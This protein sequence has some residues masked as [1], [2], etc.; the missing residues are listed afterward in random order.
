MIRKFIK[1]EMFRYLFIGGCTTLLDIALFIG[2]CQFTPLG[3]DKIGITVANTIAIILS[4]IFAYY[5]NK[6]FVFRKPYIDVKHE[7]KEMS[8]F[9]I[10][11]FFT[12]LIEIGG[13][14]FALNVLGQPKLVGK[15]EI[16]FVVVVMNY[17]LS[18]F[19][20]FKKDEGV[21]QSN[22]VRDQVGL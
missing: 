18:K 20:V 1:S 3:N 15:I 11:R 14:Y 9:F 12:M 6:Y 16:Q 21:K 22:E 2:L 19:V 5:T 13:V 4:I 10:A 17:V 7:I 8:S